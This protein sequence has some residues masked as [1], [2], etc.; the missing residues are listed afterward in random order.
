MKKAKSRWIEEKK[1]KINERQ[2]EK[3]NIR[4]EMEINKKG[5]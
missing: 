3:K 5:K 2:K 4:K 1:R